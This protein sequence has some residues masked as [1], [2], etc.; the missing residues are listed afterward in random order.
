MQDRNLKL[1]AAATLLLAWGGQGVDAGAWTRPGDGG[2]P[3]RWIHLNGANLEDDGAAVLAVMP[4]NDNVQS[5][6]FGSNSFRITNVGSKTIARVVIDVS[7]A[8]YRG[9]VFDPEG[10]AGD[11]VAKPLHVDRRGGTGILDPNGSEAT[12]YVGRGASSGYH[13]LVL[14]FDPLTDGGFNPGESMGFSIDMDPNS[15]AGT[16]KQRLDAGAMPPWDVGGVS[17]AELIGSRFTVTFSDDSTATGQLHGTATQ[18]GAHAIASQRS[19]GLDVRLHVGDAPQSAVVGDAPRLPRITVQG[20]AGHTA[21]VVLTRGCIQPV[22]A[23]NDALHEQL[24]ALAS[25]TFPANNAVDFQ[26]VDVVLTGSPQV[27]TDRFDVETA[28]GGPFEAHPDRPFSIDLDELPMAMVAAIIDPANDDLPL[29]PVTA[30]IYVIHD[31][32]MGD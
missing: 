6:N 9:S 31:Q 12:H 21:R 13:A 28:P 25:S 18:A 7:D 19:P 15:I 26:T 17:G 22:T 3:A 24:R 23:Y 27:I 29:G 16:N 30:P 32:P 2:S 10:L 5:S 11:S 20:P 14:V 4:K 8:L 1:L